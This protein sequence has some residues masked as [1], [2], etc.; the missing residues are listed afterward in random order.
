MKKLTIAFLCLALL[1]GM[2]FGS[3]CF[4]PRWLAAGVAGKRPR[5][6]VVTVV[7]KEHLRLSDKQ[8]EY[9][10]ERFYVYYRVDDFRDIAPAEREAVLRRERLRYAREGPRQM[11]AGEGEYA[12]YSAG[13]TIKV[14]YAYSPSV[15]WGVS[16]EI[17]L[18]W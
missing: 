8:Y 3:R 7:K 18:P 16:D 5:T 17:R 9:P 10:G 12:A 11:A 1:L 14:Q 2:Y 15:L 4:I 6:A 13:D